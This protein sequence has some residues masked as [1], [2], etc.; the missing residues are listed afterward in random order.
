MNEHQLLQKVY[1]VIFYSTI[2]IHSKIFYY[3]QIILTNII[4][5]PSHQKGTYLDVI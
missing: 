5:S 3:P 4:L 1:T 2:S